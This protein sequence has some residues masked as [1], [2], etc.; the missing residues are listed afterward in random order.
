MGAYLG[1]LL[2]LQ[3]PQ[4]QPSS[5]SGAGAINWMVYATALLERAWLEFE[6]SHSKERSILQL[7]AL[8]DQHSNRL[9]LTQSTFSAVQ[10]Q[11]APAQDRLLHLHQLVYPPRWLMVR[12]LA[13]RYAKMGIVTSAAELFLEIELWDQVVE[14]Y[15]RAGKAALAKEIVEQRLQVN[16]TPRMWAALG[17]LTQDPQYYHKAIELSQGKFLSSL[18]GLGKVLL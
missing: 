13:E 9:T 18:C 8:N 2:Q 6:S 1:R 7:Q 14:C 15:K 11:S 12:D 3:Q 5:S 17:D 16:P 10:E 4:N